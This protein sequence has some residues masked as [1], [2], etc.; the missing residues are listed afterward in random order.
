MVIQPRDHVG[1]N[2]VLVRLLED[3]VAPAL[4]VLH[5]HVLDAELLLVS[6]HEQRKV[7]RESLSMAGLITGIIGAVVWGIMLI[8]L[9]YYLVFMNGYLVFMNR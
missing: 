7:F 6:L 1:V 4:V 3:R 2:L 5:R 8:S 9:I